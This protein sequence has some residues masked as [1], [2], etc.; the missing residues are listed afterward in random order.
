VSAAPADGE[1]V[2]EP[3]RPS[4]DVPRIIAY[5]DGPLLVRG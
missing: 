5:P 4:G 1:P 3:A 2:A